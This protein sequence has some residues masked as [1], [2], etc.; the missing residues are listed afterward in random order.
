MFGLFFLQCIVTIRKL[1][2]AEVIV[3]RTTNRS[4]AD[5]LSVNQM[6]DTRAEILTHC[7]ESQ[8]QLHSRAGHIRTGLI[9]D[10]FI[11][12]AVSCIFMRIDTLHGHTAVP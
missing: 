6:I 12:L 2:I 11:S 3:F 10:V 4:C 8:E 5:R 9:I 1:C 7:W